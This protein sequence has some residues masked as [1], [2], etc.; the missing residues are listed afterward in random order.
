MVDVYHTPIF[1]GRS[2]KPPASGS[3]IRVSNIFHHTIDNQLTWHIESGGFNGRPEKLADACY[4]WWV[5]SSLAMIDRLHWIHQV[6]ATSDGQ[7]TNASEH[8]TCMGL[9][10]GANTISSILRIASELGS[11][12]ARSKAVVSMVDQRSLQ[13]RATAGGWAI[14]STTQLTI[15]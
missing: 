10:T 1:P 5:G 7:C 13:M 2:A 11:A 9:G 12:S 4:S 14:Y 8:L 15:N 3:Y 6:Q